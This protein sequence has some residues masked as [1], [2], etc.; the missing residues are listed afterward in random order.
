MQLLF[1]NS[2]ENIVT[3]GLNLIK[4]KI[5]R[6]NAKNNILPNVGWKKTTILKN[7]Q[8]NY[9][10]K[11]NNEK[12]YYV[13]TYYA[14]PVDVKDQIGTSIYNN[15]EFCAIAIKDKNVIGAQFH[16]EKSSKIGLEFL[17]SVFKNSNN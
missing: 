16:P 17:D 11:F 10:T 2:E 4:G 7:N 12:F 8:F 15:K 5:K 13:H 9:L 14:D 3:N 6:L 1:E